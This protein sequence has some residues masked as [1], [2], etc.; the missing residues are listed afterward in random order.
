[1]DML[2]SVNGMTKECAITYHGMHYDRS[3]IMGRS[4]TLQMRD[5]IYLL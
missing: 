1:M 4:N 3:V 2:K 5:Q